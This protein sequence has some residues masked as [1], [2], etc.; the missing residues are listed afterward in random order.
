[1]S[2]KIL[3]CTLRDGGYV[4]NWHFGFN[5]IKSIIRDLSNANI[6][7]IEC[8]FLKDKNTNEKSSL[9]NSSSELKGFLFNSANYTLM[10]NYGEYPINKIPVSDSIIYRIA[11]KK[12]DLNDALDF[13]QQGK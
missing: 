11:F 7:F 5:N 2:I 4:N 12:E 13:C 6:D 9:F 10:I 8:G 3:D 1:M